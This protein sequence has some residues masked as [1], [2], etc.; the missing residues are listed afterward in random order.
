MRP[1]GESSPAMAARSSAESL[2]SKTSKLLAMRSGRTD[3]GITMKFFSRCQRMMICAG[4]AAVARRNGAD[5]RIV[6]VLALPQRTPALGGD[7]QRFMPGDQFTLLELRVQLDLVEHRDDPCRLDDAVE[8]LG[9]EVR[10]ADRAH[11]ALFLQAHQGPPRVARTGPA[12]ARA[13]GSDTGP[14]IRP[15][16]L[17]AVV[18]AL[19]RGI[20]PLVRVPQ[21]A[22]DEDFFPW[23]LRGAQ[24]RTYAGFFA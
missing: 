10:D 21:L 15:Q 4:R 22:R 19:A 13:S 7:A 20:E 2:K 5:D 23:Q 1:S 3:F 18:E 9:V 11:L 16:A 12:A 17:E 6:K 24:S 8:V 14:R